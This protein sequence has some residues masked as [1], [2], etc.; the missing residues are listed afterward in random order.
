MLCE[1]TEIVTKREKALK[2]RSCLLDAIHHGQGVR[3]PEAADEECPFFS[4]QTIVCN[5]WQIAQYKTIPKKLPLNCFNGA[6]NALIDR[7][8]QRGVADR[9]VIGDFR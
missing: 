7:V 3:K 5:F 1:Q 9:V 8:P 6:H 2:Q 4:D